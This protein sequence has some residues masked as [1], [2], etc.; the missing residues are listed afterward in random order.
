MKNAALLWLRR[1]GI[2]EGAS[3]L[4]LLFFAMPLK[5]I[6]DQP[7]FVE[8]IGMI[9]GVLF[10]VFVAFTLY[11]AMQDNWKFF[12]RTV[13]VLLSSVLPF[14]TFYIDHRILKPLQNDGMTL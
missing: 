12:N 9:H 7:I 3:L 14:G 5:Y 10:I 1:I 11:V 6:W 13:W 4:L 2:L 8:I